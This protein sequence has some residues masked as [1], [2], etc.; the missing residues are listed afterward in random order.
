MLATA[1]REFF[2]TDVKPG[3]VLLV[4]DRK[5]LLFRYALTVER[6]SWVTCVAGFTSKISRP[7]GITV[8]SVLTDISPSSTLAARRSELF[9]PLE[10]SGVAAD[11][12]CTCAPFPVRFAALAPPPAVGTTI[13][14]R[15]SKWRVRPLQRV[16]GHPGISSC[17]RF[18]SIWIIQRAMMGQR[19][20]HNSNSIIF[21]D[22]RAHRIRQI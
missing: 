7:L 13:S 6:I 12:C 9:H 10:S 3:T 15:S 22:C 14:E 1:S 5:P 21:S 20:R 17:A 2:D 16:P 8:D 4:A 19:W 18:G 11:G